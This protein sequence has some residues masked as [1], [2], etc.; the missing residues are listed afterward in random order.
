M[1]DQEISNSRFERTEAASESNSLSAMSI[2]LLNNDVYQQ[3][4][5]YDSSKA[6]EGNGFP[7]LMIDD[8]AS[9]KT[10]SAQ[11]KSKY[12]DAKSPFHTGEELTTDRE[13][14]QV[15]LKPENVKHT[16]SKD[17]DG[18]YHESTTVK[19]PNGLEVTTSGEHSPGRKMGRVQVIDS[20]I[21]TQDIKMPKDW[22]QDAEGTVRDTKGN[23]QAQVNN[24]GSVT[25]KVG[26]NYVNQAPN[27][28]SEE[29]G[30]IRSRQKGGG[31]VGNI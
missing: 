26:D 5:Q 16:S 10:E 18:D 29:V 6:V 12:T 23:V 19:Y 14:R 20:E 11:F 21:K 30:V 27:G 31:K 25:V 15:G 7:S 8:G 28:V 3:F 13:L 22:T 9:A 2:E 1:A 4:N 24:D 17:A